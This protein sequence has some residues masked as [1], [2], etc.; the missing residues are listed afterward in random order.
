MQAA[1]PNNTPNISTLLIFMSQANKV[2]I[3]TLKLLFKD[4]YLNRTLVWDT[5]KLAVPAKVRV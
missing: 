5:F 3:P 4:Y 2:Y 1:C